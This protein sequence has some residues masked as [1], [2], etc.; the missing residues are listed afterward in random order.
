MTPPPMIT[1]RARPGRSVSAIVT[2]VLALHVV[3]QPGVGRAGET[4]RGDLEL[5]HRPGPEVEV[6]VAAGVLDRTPQRPAITRDQPVELRTGDPAAPRSAV[7]GGHEGGQRVGAQPALGDHVP[8]LETG[9]V[10]ARVLIVDEPEPLAV[11]DEIG[12]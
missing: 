8:K 11:V 10:V 3:E 7:V 1:T 6:Q 2:S 5:R 12:G 9:V 4:G